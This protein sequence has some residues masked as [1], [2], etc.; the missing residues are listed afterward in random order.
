MSLVGWLL[1]SHPIFISPFSQL[2]TQTSVQSHTLTQ[3]WG[4]KELT[5]PNKFP[6]WADL[7]NW[8][9]VF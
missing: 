6:D 9:G 8:F 2:S 1:I 5:D 7:Q 3:L 4:P